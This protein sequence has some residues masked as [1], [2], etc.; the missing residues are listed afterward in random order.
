M[1][2]TASRLARPPAP[3]N[4]PG[5]SRCPARVAVPSE[6]CPN[7]H[8][9][10]GNPSDA[11]RG[12]GS[13]AQLLS[14]YRRQAGGTGLGEGSEA[15]ESAGGGPRRGGL[16]SAAAAAAAVIN[17]S[18]VS[19]TAALCKRRHPRSPPHPEGANGA[20][21]A[22]LQSAAVA[23]APLHFRGI[24][25]DTARPSAGWPPGRSAPAGPPARAHV[26]GSASTAT[27]PHR[28]PRGVPACGRRRPR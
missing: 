25:G 18:G 5:T 22:S 14:L 7:S 20:S 8:A 17:C 12:I 26:A 2:K 9:D 6:P 16:R 23:D 1:K 28:T 13:G 19:M 24:T 15:M 21:R 10:E 27:T 11:L 4:S 3:A